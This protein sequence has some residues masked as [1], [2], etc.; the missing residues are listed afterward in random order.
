MKYSDYYIRRKI[1]T[2]KEDAIDVPFIE[3]IDEVENKVRQKLGIALLDLPDEPF[4]FMYEQNITPIDA[5]NKC[6]SNFIMY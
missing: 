3:W 5:S 6:V 4:M 1:A 2:S